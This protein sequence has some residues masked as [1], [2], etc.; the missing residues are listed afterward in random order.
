M[1]GTFPCPRCGK[2]LKY[3][4]K[5]VTCKCD[6]DD[7]YRDAAFSLAASMQA[8]PYTEGVAAT[9]DCECGQEVA[10]TSGTG[11]CACGRCYGVRVV[12][13]YGPDA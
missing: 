8:V 3:D 1:K 13:A 4:N 6:P 10:V 11:I 12:A 5:D 7:T 9:V 2:S